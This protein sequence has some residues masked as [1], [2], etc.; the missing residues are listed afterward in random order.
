MKCSFTCHAQVFCWG[1][2]LQFL[3]A[4][5]DSTPLHLVSWFSCFVPLT[6]DG[7][8]GSLHH[9]SVIAAFQQFPEQNTFGR[10]RLAKRAKKFASE[11]CEKF[12]PTKLSV[13]DRKKI[14]GNTNRKM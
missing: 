4:V 9:I 12:Y 5:G 14:K 3:I 8:K 7:W 6:S 13:L 11:I 10:H 1:L 2:A